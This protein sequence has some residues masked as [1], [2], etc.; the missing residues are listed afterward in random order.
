MNY[1]GEKFLLKLYQD[2]YKD[3][4]VRHSSTKSDNKY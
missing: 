4:S 3:E 2:M 1:D